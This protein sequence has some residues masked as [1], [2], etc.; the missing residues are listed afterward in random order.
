M[1][2]MENNACSTLIVQALVLHIN[3]KH[4]LRATVQAPI[5]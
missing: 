4:Q 3:I 5:S 1:L 2:G